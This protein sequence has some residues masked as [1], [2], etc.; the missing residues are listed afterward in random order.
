M[1]HIKPRG[2]SLR[3]SL[4]VAITLFIRLLELITQKRS[5]QQQ[6]IAAKKYLYCIVHC[7]YCACNSLHV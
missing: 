3:I 7:Y 1:H 2:E 5:N 6:R 4:L